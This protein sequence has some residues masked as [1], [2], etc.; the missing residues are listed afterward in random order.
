ML[1]V[2]IVESQ[3]SKLGLIKKQLDK[4]SQS[5]QNICL[6]SF[7][8]LEPA[9][10]F[11]SSQLRELAQTYQHDEHDEALNIN[12]KQPFALVLCDEELEDGSAWELKSLLTKVLARHKQSFLKRQLAAG[13]K[14]SDF[15]SKEIFESP[16][17]A[18]CSKNGQISGQ[19]REKALKAQVEYILRKPADAETI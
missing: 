2:L 10:N 7:N 17:F 12:F 19:L 16:T 5:R 15:E 11:V 9:M 8:A 3:K 13:H 4:S 6:Y 18:L 14:L 1:L